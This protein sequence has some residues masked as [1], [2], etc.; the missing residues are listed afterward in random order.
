MKVPIGQGMWEGGRGRPPRGQSTLMMRSVPRGG[1]RG[2][3]R[4]LGR[5]YLP[6]MPQLS[7]GMAFL[8]MSPTATRELCALG[9][10]P[11]SMWVIEVGDPAQ[12]VWQGR[13]GS[14]WKPV[15]RYVS[16]TLPRTHKE[17]GKKPER[18]ASNVK[19][20]NKNK[21]KNSAELQE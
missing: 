11:S 3:C 1:F 16:V 5:G 10:A 8:C 6:E 12:R 9:A 7:A 20:N 13:D 2:H 14:K 21:N 15:G 18:I 17:A 4:H 19:K